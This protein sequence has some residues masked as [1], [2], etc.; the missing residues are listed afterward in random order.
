MKSI[1][2]ILTISGV[3]A[4]PDRSGGQARPKIAL[5]R[6]V[7]TDPI[8][9]GLVAKLDPRAFWWPSHTQ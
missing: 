5:D 1:K 6:A 8:E 2:N 4:M 7:K 3:M 9:L